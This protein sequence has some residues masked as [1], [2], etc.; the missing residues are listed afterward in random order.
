M[1]LPQFRQLV[2]VDYHKFMKNRAQRFE[3]ANVIYK[4]NKEIEM[5]R[6]NT[7]TCSLVPRPIYINK[8]RQGIFWQGTR[9]SE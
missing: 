7:C 6:N 4:E 3:I 5:T 2:L 8:S 1:H 9:L